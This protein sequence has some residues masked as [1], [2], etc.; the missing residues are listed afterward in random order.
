MPLARWLI[1]ERYLLTE[2]RNQG[3]TRIML[4]NAYFDES[5]TE[6]D[7]VVAMGGWVID[8]KR[9]RGFDRSW[10]Q[11]LKDYGV[12]EFH[13]SPL[14]AAI[15]GRP[16]KKRN[17]FDG[18]SIAKA[19]NFRAALSGVINRSMAFGVSCAVAVE[20]YAREIVPY[21]TDPARPLRD[22]YRWVMQ[23]CL[24]FL[25]APETDK[26]SRLLRPSDRVEVI[27]DAGHHKPGVTERYF[28]KITTDETHGIRAREGASSR[29]IAP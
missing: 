24:D 23:S 13:G 16:S 18:W 11:V 21:L 2:C 14:A 1:L 22:P 25:V 6:A 19:K 27:F 4:L 15:E 20:D 12:R 10:R 9:L 28:L 7:P 8:P 5:G 26:I 17:E 29:G 3:V